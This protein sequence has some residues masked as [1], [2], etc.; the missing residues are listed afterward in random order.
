MGPAI[1]EIE[2]LER[3]EIAGLGHFTAGSRITLPAVSAAVL[4]E[5][6]KALPVVGGKVKRP[7]GRPRKTSAAK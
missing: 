4:I 7:R 1:Q 6:K 3:V 2:T 5:G